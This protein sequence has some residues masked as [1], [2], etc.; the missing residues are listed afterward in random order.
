MSVG[1]GGMCSSPRVAQRWPTRLL[2]AAP[3]VGDGVDVADFRRYGS[4]RR[5]YNFTIDDVDAL[6]AERTGA[7]G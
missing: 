6:E 1:G 7:V 4:A 5:L 2:A 3:G